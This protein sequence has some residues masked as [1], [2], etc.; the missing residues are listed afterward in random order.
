VLDGAALELSHFTSNDAGLVGVQIAREGEADLHGL[1]LRERTDFDAA[2]RVIDW[3][4]LEHSAEVSRNPIGANVQSED[5]DLGRIQDG[6][7][8]RDNVRTLDSTVLP[9]PE[10]L[11]SIDD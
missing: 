11:V 6:V 3:E 8:Y 1:C 5:F 9:V 4:C 7:L 2:G 10:S